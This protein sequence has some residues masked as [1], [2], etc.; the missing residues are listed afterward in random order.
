[1]AAPGK[2]GIEL[3]MACCNGCVR[4]YRKAITRTRPPRLFSESRPGNNVLVARSNVLGGISLR[5]TTR[6]RHFL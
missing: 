4:C 2:Y 6:V 1:M 3:L 5:I